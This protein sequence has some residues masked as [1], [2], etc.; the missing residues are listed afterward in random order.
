MVIGKG[1]KIGKGCRLK[2]C[3]L[4]GNTIIGDGVYLEAT[5]VSYRCKIGN[6]ARVEG[7]TVLAEDV[8]VKED[9]RVTECMVLSHKSIN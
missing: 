7:L 5:I 9:V 1:C 2:D 8:V 4:I 3:T 6:W